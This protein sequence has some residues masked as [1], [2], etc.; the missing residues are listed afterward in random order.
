MIVDDYLRTREY[1]EISVVGDSAALA[2]KKGNALPPTAQTAIQRGA[3]AAENV[4]RSQ[5]NRCLKKADLH[6]KGITIAL[7]GSYASIDLGAIRIHGYPAYLTK[8]FI[9][10][11]YKW[12][13]WW[14]ASKGFKKIE[15]C[16]V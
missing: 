2:D 4:I 1:E 5:Q 7:G 10:R 12:P 15:T 16:S 8:K 11:L 3:L 9:E 13:L 6:L 14:Q